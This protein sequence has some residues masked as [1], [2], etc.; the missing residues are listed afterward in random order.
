MVQAKAA[1]ISP[2]AG[3]QLGPAWGSNNASDGPSELRTHTRSPV[4]HFLVMIIAIFCSLSGVIT[5]YVHSPSLPS[6]ASVCRTLKSNRTRLTVLILLALVMLLCAQDSGGSEKGGFLSN[7]PDF[8]N[9]HR[10][11]EFDVIEAYSRAVSLKAYATASSGGASKMT[12]MVLDSGAGRVISKQRAYFP[13]GF[14]PEPAAIV[15]NGVNSDVTVNTVGTFEAYF[16]PDNT[17][18][19]PRTSPIS[20]NSKKLLEKKPLSPCT[21]R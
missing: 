6:Y 5:A 21:L 1:R 7:L 20:L 14:N 18:W 4:A 11:F 13:H 9:S 12:S 19:E 17:Y 15:I 10:I 16:T 8:D 2:L 3:A